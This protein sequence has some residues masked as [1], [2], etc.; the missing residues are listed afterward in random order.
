MH[1]RGVR[2]P[3]CRRSNDFEGVVPKSLVPLG[4]GGG[5]MLKRLQVCCVP[6][7]DFT[8][9][10]FGPSGGGIPIS[11]VIIFKQL[12]SNQHT[13]R[14]CGLVYSVFVLCGRRVPVAIY[15]SFIFMFY[16]DF[17]QRPRQTS[18]QTDRSTDKRPEHGVLL[19][20][21]PQCFDI[22]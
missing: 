20:F 13:S 19:E 14:V 4:G 9:A 21:A 18:R 16:I 3:E 17:R 15:R 12:F 7:G 22:V 2:A 1:L 11:P 10:R 6:K 5:S 8:C